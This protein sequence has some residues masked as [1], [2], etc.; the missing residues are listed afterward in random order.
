MTHLAR[1]GFL[2]ILVA[3]TVGVSECAIAAP[4]KTPPE[5]AAPQTLIVAGDIAGCD[6]TGDEAT[7][8]IVKQ[9]EGTVVTTGDNAYPDGSLDQYRDC[10]EPSWGAFRDRTRPVPG[11]HEYRT[12]GAAGYFEYFGAAAGEA[13]KGWYAFDLGQWRIY[14]LNSNC[15]NVGCDASSEQV[16]WLKADLAANPR[17]CVAGVWHHPRFSSGRHGNHGEVA[18]FWDVL[19]EAGADVILNGHEHSYERLRPQDP[20]A[21]P[22]AR[23]IRTF[24]VGT[25]GKSFYAM[26]K[27]KPNSEVRATDVNGILQL[28][29]YADHYEWTFVPAGGAAFRDR[30]TTHCSPG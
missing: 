10:Y 21:H 5:T 4:I 9:L 13:G 30:G 16:R 1:A 19:H 20:D 11:N 26:K 22:D 29:L 2:L 25:G 24:V 8:A 3:L 12:R 7:A 18:P 27:P 17:T 23:G 28:S 14:M 15:K 6:S